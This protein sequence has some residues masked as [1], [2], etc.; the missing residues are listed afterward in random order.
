MRGRL[1]LEASAVAVSILLLPAVAAAQQQPTEPGWPSPINNNP[2]LGYAILNQ[3]ELRLG[4]DTTYRWDGEGWF[5]G[6]L[7]R[8]WVKSEG[9]LETSSGSTREAEVQALY[10]R[11]ISPFFNLQMGTRYDFY[12]MPSRGWAALGI[13]GLA[14]LGWDIDAFVFAS[15]GGHLGAR[16]ESYYDLYLTQR[17]VL[18]PQFELNAYSRADRLTLTGTGLSD[19]DFGLR[20][21]YEIRREFAPYV[22]V[23]YETAF[24]STADLEREV[25]QSSSQLRFVVGIHAWL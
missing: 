6:N 4:D 16:L 1:G 10:S 25:R 9:S 21:R 19:G 13:E 7:N 17:L 3:N 14:P 5:G 11:A 22:G 23:T 2:L 18:Q 15:D 8:L 24:G 20:L 12:P